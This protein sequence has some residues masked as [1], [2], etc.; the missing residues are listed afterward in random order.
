M[1][2][3][4]LSRFVLKPSRNDSLIWSIGASAHGFYSHITQASFRYHWRD[5]GVATNGASAHGFMVPCRYARSVGVGFFFLMPP[6]PSASSM[7]FFDSRFVAT[8]ASLWPVEKYII[9]PF[10]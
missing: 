1:A 8:R 9:W 10:H 6:R 7:R 3:P 5:F 2:L 4:A